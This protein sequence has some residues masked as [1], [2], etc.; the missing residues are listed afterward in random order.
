MIWTASRRSLIPRQR[1][2]PARAAICRRPTIALKPECIPSAPTTRPK[3]RRS[4]PAKATSSSCCL[5]NGDI[6]DA[7]CG[8]PNCAQP[9]TCSFIRGIWPG[10]IR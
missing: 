1:F 5:P 6:T 9:V 3:R 4:P 7:A 2:L 8:G 10:M